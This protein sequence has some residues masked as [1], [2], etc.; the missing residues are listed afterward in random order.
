[1]PD[2]DATVLTSYDGGPAEDFALRCVGDLGSL[3]GWR[4]GV[5]GSGIG[6]NVQAIQLAVQAVL[7]L[8]AGGL[9]DAD[10]QQ[11]QPA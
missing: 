11:R 3:A 7:C 10:Q 1:M 9:H 8:V 6:A 2:V 5:D 4:K